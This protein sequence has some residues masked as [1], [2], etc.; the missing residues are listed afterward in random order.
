MPFFL[1]S[2][3][4]AEIEPLKQGGAV[5]GH[6]TEVFSTM[7]V[8]LKELHLQ[9]VPGI[10]YTSVSARYIIEA[11][12][13]G[14][15]TFEFNVAEL[16]PLY[17]D[18]AVLVVTKDFEIWVDGQKTKSTDSYARAREDNLPKNWNALWYGGNQY[19]RKFTVRF[20]CKKGTH[21]LV[22]AYLQPN[23]ATA[24]THSIFSTYSNI[25]P[26]KFAFNLGSLASWGDG[27]LNKLTITTKDTFTLA[28]SQ[29]KWQLRGEV[30][31][32]SLVGSWENIKLY[33]DSF[34]TAEWV[35][36]FHHLLPQMQRVSLCEIAPNFPDCENVKALPDTLVV[37]NENYV[38]IIQ[39]DRLQELD[40]HLQRV[41]D[42]KDCAIIDLKEY[43]IVSG[44]CAGPFEK[45]N[46]QEA[47]IENWIPGQA[48][49]LGDWFVLTM[50]SN[51]TSGLP[52]YQPQK[53]GT[54]VP[55]EERIVLRRKDG[56]PIHAKSIYRL[57]RE[58]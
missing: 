27:V 48:H 14:E 37:P 32:D 50:H 42:Q 51:G 56:T 11:D 6:P 34:V 47:S 15:I 2:T 26:I 54:F 44:K 53:L 38:L 46:L 1:F 22:L 3:V 17:N 58:G 45:L 20:Q 28:P 10:W 4:L 55:S 25:T 41:Y 36:F 29:M 57:W 40:F 35:A 39:V 49:Y 9:I 7:A 24:F 30:W 8:D 13:D 31:Q 12:D 19:Q 23:F 18:S 5:G 52:M 43:R 16:E 21:E 33:Y